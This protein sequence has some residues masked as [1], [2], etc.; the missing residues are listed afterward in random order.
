MSLTKLDERCALVVI[1]LQK[2]IVEMPTVHPIAEILDRAAR[3]AQAFRA[4]RIASRSGQ[5]RGHGTGA[6]GRGQT[7]DFVSENW[8]ELAAG[9]RRAG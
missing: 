5:R 8:I 1:D 3:L 7:D 9:I 6:N 2:G 4:A